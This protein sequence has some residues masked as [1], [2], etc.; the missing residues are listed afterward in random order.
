MVSPHRRSRQ[1]AIRRGAKKNAEASQSFPCLF[2]NDPHRF[3]DVCVK[4]DQVKDVERD[5]AK[6]LKFESVAD[7]TNAGIRVNPR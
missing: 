3:Y 4:A 2:E 6:A 5:L 7:M 1:D